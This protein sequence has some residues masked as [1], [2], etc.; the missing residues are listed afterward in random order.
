MPEN[1]FIRLSPITQ[2]QFAEISEYFFRYMQ[3]IAGQELLTR[4]HCHVFINAVMSNPKRELFWAIKEE[5]PCGFIFISIEK[6]WPILETSKAK[7]NE[8]YIFPE[9]RR[10]KCGKHLLE[11]MMRYLSGRNCDSIEL[12]VHFNNSAGYLFWQAMGFEIKKHV[13]HKPLEP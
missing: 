13:L 1:N 7:I 3:E 9:M 10:Q 6:N 8:F 2:E 4:E 5:K 11:E 12:E